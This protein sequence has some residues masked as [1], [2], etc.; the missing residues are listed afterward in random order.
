M[1]PRSVLLLSLVLDVGVPFSTAPLRVPR[2]MRA[3]SSRMQVL[4]GGGGLGG[5]FKHLVGDEQQERMVRE[6]TEALKS[7][8]YRAPMQ[9]FACK[10][11]REAALLCHREKRGVP[12]ACQQVTDDLEK[13]AALVRKAA[14]VKITALKASPM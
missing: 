11:E 1:P 2:M 12:A 8:E 5:F 14:M 3:P 9:A 10:E 13:C 7:R 4:G 6:R